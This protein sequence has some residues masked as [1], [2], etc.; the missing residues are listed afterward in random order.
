M[1]DNFV[2]GVDG[3]TKLGAV[4]YNFGEWEFPVEGGTRKFF[5]FGH[6]FQRTLPGGKSAQITM[7]GAYNAGNMP[8]AVGVVYQLHL[9]WMAGI[10]IVVSGRLDKVRYSNKTGQGGEP[11]GQAECV[12][13]SE[14]VFG[15]SF[16]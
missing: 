16:T 6:D 9:G 12:F 1:P 2:S 3:Y 15:I 4:A 7:R 10:E 5:A 14:G 8:L 13:E 11:G